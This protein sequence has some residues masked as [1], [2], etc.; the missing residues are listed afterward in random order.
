MRSIFPDL[1]QF[2]QKDKL[3]TIDKMC[4][5]IKVNTKESD[6][7]LGYPMIRCA[8]QRSVVLDS[9]GASMLIEGNPLGLMQWHKEIEE[10]KNCK[11][12]KDSLEFFKK[13]K[14][15]YLILDHRN[16]VLGLKP[17]HKVETICLYKL[18]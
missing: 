12:T 18:N 5:Y 9:K 1:N 4:E 8:A 14:V 7:F 10:I 6:V 3:K 2:K 15:N 11:T 13:K 17:I 16:S